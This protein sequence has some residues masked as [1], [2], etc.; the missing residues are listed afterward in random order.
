MIRAALFDLDGVVRRF[1]VAPLAEIERRHGLASRAIL[2]ALLDPSRFQ[3]A[4]T[5]RISDEAWRESA[6]G[7]LGPAKRDF[8]AW[9]GLTGHVDPTV[10]AIVR[11]VRRR[12]PVGLLT[13]ATSR[14]DADLARLGIRNEFDAVVN[15]SAIGVAKPDRGAFEYAAKA[16]GFEL[17]EIVFVDDTA[18]NVEAAADFGFVVHRFTGVEALKSF[19][20]THELS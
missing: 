15:T 5:G 14:L 10:L 17:S 13:N 11:Q 9:D 12:V 2:T 16:L 7:A 18:R 20:L 6:G 4:V 8:L 3:D 1:D 19:L